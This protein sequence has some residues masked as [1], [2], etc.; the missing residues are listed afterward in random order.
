MKHLTE[1]NLLP[2]RQSA[3]R[4]YHS[5]ETALLSIFN[6][7]L[8]S[9]DSGWSTILLL[10][11]L[12]AAFDTLDHAI[13]LERL[14]SHC[15]ISGK[16]LD[17]F[18]SFLSER[19]QSIHQ[20]S[21]SSTPLPVPFGVPQGSVLGG[22][23]FLAYVS[24]LLAATAVTGVTVDQFSD[25]TQARV[26]FKPTSNGLE[27]QSAFNSLSSWAE[28]ADTWYIRNRVKLNPP[29]STIVITNTKRRVPKQSAALPAPPP[30]SIGGISVEPSTEA[31]NLGVIID[32]QLTLASHIRLVCKASFYHIWRIGRI[33]HLIDTATTKCLISAFVLSRINYAIT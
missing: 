10:L 24:T 6:D 5:T 30:F 18:A 12:C 15:L 20:G 4:P 29:K 19:T 31:K 13:L 9:A 33:R 8:L 16:V 32:N 7:L 1:N 3:Y 2:E 22:P 14:N 25:D 17:W 21:H 27:Q 28:N 23:L 11:D 26:S